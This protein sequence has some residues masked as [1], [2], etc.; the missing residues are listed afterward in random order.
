MWRNPLLDKTFQAGG[1]VLPYRLLKFGASD[2]QLIQA[3]AATDGLLGVCGQVG[4]ATGEAVEATLIGIGEVTLG[5]TVTRG[6]RLTADSQGRAIPA[7]D[8]D[9]VAG[10]AL[11]SGVLADVVP[12]LLHAAGDADGAPLYQ[13]DVTVTTAQVKAL[14][15]TPVQ[16]VAAPGTGLMIVP[17]L[18]QLYLPYVSAAYACIAA[19][20]DLE[21]R[22]TNGS[23]TLWATIET[24]GFLD[25]TATQHRVV[26]PT[27]AAAFT[28]AANAPLVLDLAAGEIITGDS[29]LKVRTYY[30]LLPSTL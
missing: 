4:A 29:P 21:I 7:A 11:K 15:A 23:G 5:G 2:T 19:G 20:E 25:Q 8:G 12:L 16:L 13:A 14:N 28:P 27:A 22:Y 6:Q 18:A 9:V 26:L 3:S 1:T 30:R 24:T 17:V 10:V